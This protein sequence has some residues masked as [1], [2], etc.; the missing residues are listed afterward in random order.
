MA[1]NSKKHAPATLNDRTDMKNN[2]LPHDTTNG[3]VQ[4]KPL[5]H[6]DTWVHQNSSHYFTLTDNETSNQLLPLEQHHMVPLPMMPQQFDE[7]FQALQQQIQEQHL[8]LEAKIQSFLAIFE[9]QHDNPSQT[10]SPS[11]HETP[12]LTRDTHIQ[13]SSN[14]FLMSTTVLHYPTPTGITVIL[15][16]RTHSTF[17]VL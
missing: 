8:I 12:R 4:N 11:W 3:S 1:I 13:R 9:Q 10:V 5:G 6:H 7:V 17:L 16:D 14:I 2:S 15:D